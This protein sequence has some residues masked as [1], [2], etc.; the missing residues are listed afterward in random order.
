MPI[1]KGVL[2]CHQISPDVYYPLGKITSQG[3]PKDFMSY[4][5][6]QDVLKPPLYVSMRLRNV[7]VI[8]ILY[9]CYITKVVSIV[10]QV[11]DTERGNKNDLP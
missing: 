11:D 6:P 10:K 3:R 4:R 5:L 1:E 9:E 2:K 7:Q 8:K